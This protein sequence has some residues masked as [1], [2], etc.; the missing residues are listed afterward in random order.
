MTNEDLKSG[1]L[2]SRVL[3]STTMAIVILYAARIFVGMPIKKGSILTDIKPRK[4]KVLRYRKRNYP[5]HITALKSGS[6]RLKP[7]LVA[8]TETILIDVKSTPDPETGEEDVTKVH[9][10]YAA[11]V[12]LVRPGVVIDKGRIYTYY[13]EDYT[14]KVF[15]SFEERI[16]YLRTLSIG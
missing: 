13:S 2:T 1:M 6:T 8:D 10:P 15:K 11:G 9:F 14:S 16:S 5:T 4:A 12:L 7:F 3:N